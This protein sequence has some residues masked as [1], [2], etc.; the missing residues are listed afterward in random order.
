MEF[1]F[2]DCPCAPPVP[3]PA[4]DLGLCPWQHWEQPGLSQPCLAVF[5]R[6]LAGLPS[7]GKIHWR[8]T[9]KIRSKKLY[10]TK[11]L[12]LSL[13]A[14]GF[15]GSWGGLSFREPDVSRDPRSVSAC[16]VGSPEQTWSPLLPSPGV[17]STFGALCPLLLSVCIPLVGCFPNSS[18]EESEQESQLE[19]QEELQQEL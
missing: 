4:P 12:P 11:V 15:V 5:F 1:V 19:L 6:M 18:W 3:D 9:K 2:S 7:P 16:S 14:V 13:S 17:Q 8:I 10:D